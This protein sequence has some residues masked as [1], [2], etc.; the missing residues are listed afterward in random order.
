MK[1]KLKAL[2]QK[3]KKSPKNE[4]SQLAKITNNTLENERKEILDNGQKF[5]YPV[6]YSK[7]KLVIN[8]IIIAVAFLII[9]AL[10]VVFQLYAAQSSSSILYRIT[11]VVPFPVANIDGENVLYSDYLMRYRAEMTISEKK[12]D[13][14]EVIKDESQR[15][16]VYK[17]QAME[18]AI[19]NALVIKLARENN[20]SVSKEEVQERL[21]NLRKVQNQEISETAFDKIVAD[22][23]G[24]SMDEYRRIFVELP[25]LKQKV[26]AEI[27]TQAK[28]MKDEVYKTLKANSNDFGKVFEQY[29]EK[30]E[31]EAPG[32]VKLSNVDGGRAKAALA[33]NPGEISQ[34]FVAD[35]NSGYYIVKLI[36]KTDKDVTYESINIAFTEFD[37]RLKQLEADGKIAKYIKLEE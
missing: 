9:G 21:A 15:M 26:S 10:V 12:K 28:K 6:Q 5:K 3:V 22:N 1:T 11:T 35:N 27:D 32:A 18:N 24:L 20:I 14:L 37:N 2:A 17:K 4:E 33:L 30:V 7:H 16:N 13:V 36:S 25:L 19:Q 29:G 8:T 31:I 23:Y 34:P